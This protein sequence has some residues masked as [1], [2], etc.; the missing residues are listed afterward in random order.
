MDNT[1]LVTLLKFKRWIDAETLKVIK[2]I[3]ESA[4]AEKRHLMLRLMNHIYVVDMI[5]RANISG[6]KHG[7]TALNTPETPSADELE[8]KM[9]DCI[10]WYIQ[11]VSSM[12]PADLKET[13]KFSF[14]DGSEGE[15]T[16]ADMI[17]HMLFHGSYHRGAVGWLISEC[18]GTPPKDVLTVFLRDH[19]H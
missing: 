18:K 5:F 9:N 10:N 8:V 6:H 17:N 19:N 7:Y 4:Y 13:I 16:A 1:S 12:S 2:G 15:M 14:V 3:S 11:R